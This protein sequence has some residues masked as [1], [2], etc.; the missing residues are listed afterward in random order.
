[1]SKDEI[2]ENEKWQAVANCDKSYD[3][4]FFYGVKTTGIFCRPSCSSKTPARN[5]IV[6]FDSASAAMNAGF[7]ICKR[8]CPDKTDYAPGYDL[9]EKLKKLLLE[10]YDKEINLKELSNSLGASSHHLERLFKQYNGL[11]PV[12]YITKLR[13][14]RS[15]ILLDKGD[16]DI[17]EI[18]YISGFKSLSNFYKQFKKYT[19]SAPKEY[20]KNRSGLRIN[21]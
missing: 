5:N 17:L 15:L 12:Q 9:A 8:C 20:R 1:M 11:T 16:K 4:I 19:G 6:Y 7:R 18:A 3:G 13:I 21:T 14:N 10:A 2:T